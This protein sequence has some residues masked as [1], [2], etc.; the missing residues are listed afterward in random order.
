VFSFLLFK[1]HFENTPF[2]TA[3]PPASRLPPRDRCDMCTVPVSYCALPYRYCA[4]LCS[5]VPVLC[6]TVPYCAVPYRTVP[7]CAVNVLCHGNPTVS[8]S[9]TV[10]YRTGV[11]WRRSRPP[12]NIPLPYTG[13]R[14]YYFQ[15]T[16]SVLSIFKVKL[17][18]RPFGSLL[19]TEWGL[20]F[21]P[22]LSIHDVPQF[23]PY[24]TVKVQSP[25]SKV[26]SPGSKV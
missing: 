16:V 8:R 21:P 15:S 17:L 20:G 7:Y 10:R 24:R 6:C 25:K 9:Y 12:R 13:I 14:V 1:G 18:D 11:L 22:W 3:W 26:Q 23:Y 4:V 5:T 19:P 2:E